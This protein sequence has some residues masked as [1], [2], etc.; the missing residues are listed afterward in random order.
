[1][2]I[3]ELKEGCEV[4]E[5]AFD[6]SHPRAA[7]LLRPQAQG[8]WPPQYPVTASPNAGHTSSHQHPLLLG[9]RLYVEHHLVPG[10]ER[11]ASQVLGSSY[12]PF[13]PPPPQLAWQAG[14]LELAQPLFPFSP[15]FPQLPE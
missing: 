4:P 14:P 13:L 3:R 9:S 11:S 2:P 7:G 15:F 5:C 8:R 12:L 1:M 6:R 10:P